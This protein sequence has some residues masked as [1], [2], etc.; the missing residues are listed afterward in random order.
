MAINKLQRV[1][2][3]LRSKKPNTTTFT[4]QQ[5]KRAIM[6]EIGTDP[7]TIKRNRQALKTLGWIKTTKTL[8]K[9][10]NTDLE[11]NF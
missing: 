10:T 7:V 4:N 5:L 8:I 1:L 11:E 9:L 6:L 2:W 3:R